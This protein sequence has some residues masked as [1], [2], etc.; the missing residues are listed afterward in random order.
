MKG[1]IS[2]K[3]GQKLSKWVGYF[4]KELKPIFVFRKNHLSPLNFPC[5][6]ADFY[7]AWKSLKMD[8]VQLQINFFPANFFCILEKGTLAGKKFTLQ[9]SLFDWKF[10]KSFKEQNPTIHLK[11]KEKSKKIDLDLNHRQLLKKHV[12]KIQFFLSIFFYLPQVKKHSDFTVLPWIL[13]KERR[14]QNWPPE[15]H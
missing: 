9:K 7:G 15:S 13:L 14:I 1:K 8:L 3:T 12:I 6:L 2:N 5:V 11:L 10:K 4:Q